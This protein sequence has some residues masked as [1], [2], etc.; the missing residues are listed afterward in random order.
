ME[1]ESRDRQRKSYVMMR[2]I[3]DTGM[4]AFILLIGIMI[5]FGDKI[6]VV[7]LTNLVS[8]ID[9]IMRYL[10]GS[11]CILYGGFRLYRGIKREY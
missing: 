5:V 9:P 8:G 2:T 11:L 1:N 4:G 3:Y 6:G 7:A 10:F